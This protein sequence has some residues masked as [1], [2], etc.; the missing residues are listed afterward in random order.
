MGTPATRAVLG[1]IAA[2]I[3]VLTFHQAMWEALHVLNLPGLGMP[4]A[5]PTRPVPPFGVPLIL[6][7]CFWGGLY[8]IVFGLLV[9]RMTAPLWLCGLVLGIIAALV[10]LLVVPAIKGL[11][12][13]AGWVPLNWLRSLLINGFWGIGVGII[14]PL[15]LRRQPRLA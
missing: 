10:G 6:D 3:S 5:Y 2:A 15:I 8:G 1:F 11:P 14:L 7:L 4:P 12:I 9:P 13:G